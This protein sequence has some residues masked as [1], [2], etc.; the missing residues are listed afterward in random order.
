MSALFP[1]IGLVV[2]VSLTQLLRRRRL[3]QLRG[4]SR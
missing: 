4:G 1:I 3:A 2:A